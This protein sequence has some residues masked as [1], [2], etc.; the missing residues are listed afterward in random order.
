MITHEKI[1]A[2]CIAHF[3]SALYGTQFANC[4]WTSRDISEGFLRSSFKLSLDEVKM[5]RYNARRL[6][7]NLDI[8][9]HYFATDRDN[10]A[11]ENTACRQLLLLA[12]QE[13]IAIDGYQAQA[14]GISST[15]ADGVLIVQFDL[16]LFEIYE[17]Q[18]N[19][20]PI[21]TFV[22]KEVF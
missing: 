8:I 22:L 14:S 5:E 12:L 18:D 4:D 1:H 13:P 6:E 7:T 20:E 16:E 2:S 10:T 21:E 3:K 15:T 17:Q 11:V 19:S 9:V